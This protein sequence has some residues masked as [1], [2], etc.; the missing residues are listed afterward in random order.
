MPAIDSSKFPGVKVHVLGPP[1]IKQSNAVL[2]QRSATI[3]NLVKIAERYATHE[4][5]THIGVAL[6]RAGAA[7]KQ[8]TA[9][10]GQGV[11][12]KLAAD[13]QLVA[14]ITPLITTEA[15]PNLKAD[16]QFTNLAET[17][18]QTEDRLR[19]V[20]DDYN[21]AARHFNTYQQTW[22]FPAVVSGI[23]GVKLVPYIKADEAQRADPVI[24]FGK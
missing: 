6:G 5:D 2:K 16:A 18:K 23:K 17:L 3:G 13:R 24:E 8:V 19:N 4:R 7:M 15:P 21:G 9:A 10:Q 11:E 12:A 1:T 22:V 14:A 20:R